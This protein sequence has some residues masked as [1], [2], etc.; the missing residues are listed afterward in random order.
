MVEKQYEKG[1]R[2]LKL[3]TEIEPQLQGADYL[4]ILGY[5][6]NN[7]I[8]KA[9]AAAEKLR[10]KQPDD[11]KTLTLLAGAYL[12]KGDE[13]K[14]RDLLNQA[15]QV[16]P[17]DPSAA[18]NLARLELSRNEVDKAKSLYEE[19]LK[20]HPTHIDTLIALAQLDYQQGNIKEALARLEYIVKEN[21]QD[22]RSRVQL[23]SIY[24][25]TGQPARVIDIVREVPDADSNPYILGVTGE[26]Q[27]ALNYS[28]N[29]ESTFRKLVKLLPKSARAHYLLA[30]SYASLNQTND[31]YTELSKALEIDPN[32]L[33]AKL[34]L[35]RLDVGENRLEDAGKIISEL[36]QA[37]PSHPEVLALQGGMAT[38]ENRPKEA[39]E[40]YQK[41]FELAP[42]SQLVVLLS[43]AQWQA[44]DKDGS[45]GTY[46]NWLEK[47]PTD[48]GV[49]LALANSYLLLDSPDK[50]KA[51]F[52][53]VVELSPNN[54]LALNNLASLL[55]KEDPEKAL[56][57]TEHAFKLAPDNPVV[58][59]TLGELLLDK[60]EIVRALRLFN[61][62]SQK[63]P[64]NLDIRYHL[65]LA[66][67][68]A[69]KSDTAH[70]ILQDTLAEK[71]PFKNEQE[72]KELL[73]SL[74]G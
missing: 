11:P 1:I 38:R 2:E 71:R 29:A 43:T 50:A 54:V 10:E 44:N 26:A 9:I 67:S 24:L 42:S 36:E 45:I 61:D 49:H 8:D 65:A 15:L 51:G 72:A 46:I 33:P 64:D 18:G 16:S 62:A 27:L 63:A 52:A 48:V 25:R 55:R 21:P 47:H 53:K 13:D 19:I 32:Y 39:V 60:G 22:I 56:V 41:A 37:Y 6:K 28:A 23:A 20:Y 7:E 34:A 59:D 5:L 68:K 31:V 57:H 4:V 3:A 40:A 69:G 14:T 35:A 12:S 58:M 70:Q 66:F 30:K 73:K 17:G 74:G